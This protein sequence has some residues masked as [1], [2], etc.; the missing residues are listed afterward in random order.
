MNSKKGKKYIDE[1]YKL[2]VC[3]NECTGLLQRVELDL[4]EIAKYHSEYIKDKAV[5]ADGK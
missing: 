1:F 5:D 4:D 2:G 3:A